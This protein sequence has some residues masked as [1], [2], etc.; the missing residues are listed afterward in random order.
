MIS[1]GFEE[2]AAQESNSFPMFLKGQEL[3]GHRFVYRLIEPL[4]T[5]KQNVQSVVWK[6]KILDSDQYKKPAEL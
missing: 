2:Q 3:R 6:A 5:Q 1:I 4:A